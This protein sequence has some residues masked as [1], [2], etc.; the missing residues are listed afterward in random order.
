MI[1]NLDKFTAASV[2]QLIDS[3]QSGCGHSFT[4]LLPKMSNHE[5]DRHETLFQAG[6]ENRNEYLLLSG[7]LLL[8]F[9]F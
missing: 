4:A 1:N 7:L 3:I 9:P 2:I 5:I 8:L 6:Q